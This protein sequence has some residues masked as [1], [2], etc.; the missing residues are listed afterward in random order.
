MRPYERLPE[1]VE[2]D[3]Q[4][5]HLDLSYAAFFAAD[6]CLHDPCL[7]ERLKLETALD[8]LVTEPHP[9][10]VGLLRAV[11]D[12]VREDRPKGTGP[13]TFDIEQD[14]PY[15]CAAFQQAYGI[16]LYA[17]KDI[18]I[19]RFLALLRGI[20]EDTKLAEI[21]RI[22]STP[23]PAPT[24]HNQDRIAE[25]T[26][27]KAFYALRGSEESMQDGWA[28]LFGILQARMDQDG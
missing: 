17:D 20:P 13:R 18:H 27:L 16:D 12:L 22:R 26:R 6:G 4:V 3:G 11:I 7:T 25:L 2:Y 15:V 19:L 23:I 1:T 8:I 21:I 14:W 5:Y 24:K 9:V 10:E 28:K